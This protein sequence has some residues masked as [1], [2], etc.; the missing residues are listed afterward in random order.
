MEGFAKSE[1]PYKSIPLDGAAR[2]A[3]KRGRP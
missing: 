2:P 3:S 1:D